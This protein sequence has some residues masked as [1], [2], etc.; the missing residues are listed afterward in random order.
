MVVCACVHVYAKFV[1]CICATRVYAPWESVCPIAK[2]F[3]YQ[4]WDECSY[5]DDDRATSLMMNGVIDNIQLVHYMIY[6]NWKALAIDQ[7]SHAAHWANNITI[8]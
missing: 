1:L 2:I 8:T 3:N 5:I 6:I 4:L 7:A